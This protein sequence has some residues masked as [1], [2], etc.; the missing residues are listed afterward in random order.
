RELEILQSLG[1]LIDPEILTAE[2]IMAHSSRAARQNDRRNLRKAMKLLDDAG[3]LVGDDGVRRNA[4]GKVLEIEFLTSQPTLDRIILP[5]VTN[6]QTMGIKAK[7]NR[8]DPSQFTLRRRDRDFDMILGGYAMSLEPSTELFQWFGQE[9]V[10]YS[11]FNPAALSGPAIEVLINNIVN[12]TEGPE[13]RANAW[14]L[15]RVLRN[16]RFIVSTWYL[17]K[18]WVAYWK[19]YEHPEN[20]PPYSLGQEDL[21]W[22]NAEDAAALKSSGALR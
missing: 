1:D 8:I 22:I 4:D 11:V 13:M 12:A 17:G 6:L 18:F 2:P 14:A 9:S 10:D 16:K 19:M 7:Y 5:F 21:W 20:L 3:W 15:D